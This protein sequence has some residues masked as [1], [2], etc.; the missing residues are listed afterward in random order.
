MVGFAIIDDKYYKRYHKNDSDN[1]KT[2]MV[3]ENV[4]ISAHKIV[5]FGG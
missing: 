5:D 3:C 1:R 4:I 2:N